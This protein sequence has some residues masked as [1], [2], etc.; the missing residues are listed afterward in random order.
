LSV[1]EFYLFVRITMDNFVGK[2]GIMMGN[3]AFFCHEV[4]KMGVGDG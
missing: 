4:K 3:E 1:Q 2:G